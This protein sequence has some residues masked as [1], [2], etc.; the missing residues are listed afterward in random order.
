MDGHQYIS[1]GI[2]NILHFGAPEITSQKL[3]FNLDVLSDKH[4]NKI[5][6][7]LIF[8][9]KKSPLKVSEYVLDFGIGNI[10][11]LNPSK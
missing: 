9:G 4:E 3:I 5:N 6:L 11:N 2:I 1:K 10:P 8:A 7:L